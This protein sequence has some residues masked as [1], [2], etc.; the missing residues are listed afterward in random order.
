VGSDEYNQALSERRADGVKAY[1]IG[2]GVSAVR[3]TAVG[4]GKGVA[5]ADNASAEG[6]QQN[7]RVEVV[8]SNTPI[9]SR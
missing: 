4:K 6:R 9:A 3:L 8:V 5:I 2:Q 1:L 7:R